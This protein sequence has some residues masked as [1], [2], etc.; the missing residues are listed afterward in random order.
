[1][2]E[3]DM[4]KLWEQ[5]WDIT[6]QRKLYDFAKEYHD[7]CES[8]DRSV[9]TGTIGPD[10]IRPASNH[11][12]VLVNR[13]AAKVMKDILDRAEMQGFSRESVGIAISRFRS[14]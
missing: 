12:F 1:M 14:C 13:N 7:R 2:N 5:E 11:E 6:E 9:C 10:G 8:Y 3:R 4:R